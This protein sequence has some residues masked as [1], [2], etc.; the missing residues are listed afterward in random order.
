MPKQAVL[1]FVFSPTTI[2]VHDES[3]VAGNILKVKVF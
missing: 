2:A 3:N 1:P